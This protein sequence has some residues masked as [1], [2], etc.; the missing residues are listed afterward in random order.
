MPVAPPS[1]Q[2]EELLRG[3]ELLPSDELTNSTLELIRE[4]VREG[5]KIGEV[6]FIDQR[7]LLTFGYVQDVPLVWQY[8]KEVDDG[9]GSEW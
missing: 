3:I 6:L 1:R 5:Q 4:Q 2:S 9:Q 8:G 7:Q